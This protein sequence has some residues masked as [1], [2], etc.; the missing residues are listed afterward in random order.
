MNMSR[1]NK[2]LRSYI[3]TFINEDGGDGGGG[4]GGGYGGYG[5]GYGGYGGGGGYG[6]SRSR[7]GGGGDGHGVSDDFFIDIWNAFV[8]PLKSSAAFVEKFSSKIQA[9]AGRL[10]ETIAALAIPGYEADYEKYNDDEQER[11][12]SIHEKYKEV[13]ERTE[14]HLFT[15]DAALM[16]FLYAPHEYLT[17]RLLKHSP[18]Q[19]L[20]AIE[21]IGGQNPAI[22]G[23]VD[24]GRD[25]TNRFKHV[26]RMRGGPTSPNAIGIQNRKM[27]K[28]RRTEKPIYT[29]LGAAQ[30]GVV[31][32]TEGLWDKLKDFMSNDKLKNAIKQSPMA[33]AM[34]KDAEEYTKNYVRGFV[35][36]TKQHLDLE[37]S[38]KLDQMTSGKFSQMIGDM[39]DESKK[40]TAKLAVVGTKKA[41]KAKAAEKLNNK[42]KELP[43][44]DSHPLSKLYQ[45]GISQIKSL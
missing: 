39:D 3:R 12:N 37:N 13:F 40:N 36:M 30:E 41:L 11:L 35:Q 20:S 45:A 7:G 28:A 15:G 5:G 4:D 31:V 14:T 21:I 25:F 34:E 6:S 42:I 2:L 38:E 23:F 8:D 33:K 19:A 26:G 17:T 32:V 24:R 44:G 10:A 22:Q 18:D 43:G 29:K 16:G 1:D 9:I 27:K